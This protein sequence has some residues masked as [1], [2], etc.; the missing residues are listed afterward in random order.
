MI[1]NS[2]FLKTPPKLILLILL[3]LIISITIPGCN[4]S[5]DTYVCVTEFGK[6]YH[7]ESCYYIKDNYKK[8]TLD[9]AKESGYTACSK[10]W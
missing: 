10:C 7:K 1:K 8:I 2:N 5:S 3:L 9:K 6:K 4:K